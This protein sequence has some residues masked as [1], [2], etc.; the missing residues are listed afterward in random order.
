MADITEQKRL[1]TFVANGVLQLYDHILRENKLGSPSP[2]ATQKAL[3]K[4]AAHQLDAGVAPIVGI[5]DFLQ[6]ASTP[7]QQWGIVFDE[8]LAV[9]NERFLAQG[10]PTAFCEEWAHTQGA[11]ARDEETFMHTVMSITRD[12]QL[13]QS[14]SALRQFLIEQPVLTPYEL[15]QAKQ[16]P[17]LT[18][19]RDQLMKAYTP[20][21]ISASR[22]GQFSCCGHCGSL[23]LRVDGD[24]FECENERCRVLDS[25]PGRTIDADEEPLWLASGLR[26]YVA[27]PGLAEV[28][29]QRLL[30]DLGLTVEMWPNY[31]AYDLR[32]QI[33]NEVWA[34]DV[35]DWVN[36]FL[37]AAEAK[38]IRRM[39]NWDK[40]FYVFPDEHLAQRS[41]YLRAFQNRWNRPPNTEAL[42]MSTFMNRVKKFM[43]QGA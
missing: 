37:L 25:V 5:A 38:P 13:P 1:L 3:H 9:E 24:G 29:L 28:K 17:L 8:E 23:L 11:D 15:Q 35:K 42:M 4:L 7:L 31:D 33:H 41:D 12:Q 22:D 18:P 2:P 19:L 10:I 39:P 34:V 21:P 27:R 30:Q 36:P 14:Y 43:K 6:L 16:D 26:R 40:A 20:A 32:V